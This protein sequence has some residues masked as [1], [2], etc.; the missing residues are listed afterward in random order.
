MKIFKSPLAYLCLV[1]LVAILFSSCQSSK[2][3]CKTFTGY[4]KSN[5]QPKYKPTFLKDIR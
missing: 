5:Y 3:G 2:T 1:L 4:K